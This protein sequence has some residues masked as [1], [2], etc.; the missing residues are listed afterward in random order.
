MFGKTTLKKLIS[1]FS[2]CAY[3]LKWNNLFFTSL[4]I[5]KEHY[6]KSMFNNEGEGLI[7]TIKPVCDHHYSSI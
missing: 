6:K 3:I 2:I 4:I 5:H 7:F 1:Y